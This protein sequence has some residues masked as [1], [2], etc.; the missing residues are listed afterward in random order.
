MSGNLPSHDE[1]MVEYESVISNEPMEEVM[2][3]VFFIF[4]PYE[5]RF[6]LIRA[7]SVV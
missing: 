5:L 4:L 1:L 3:E 6:S 2:F 7:Y